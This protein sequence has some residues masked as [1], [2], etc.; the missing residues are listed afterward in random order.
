MQICR[1]PVDGGLGICP[2]VPNPGIWPGVPIPGIWPGVLIPGNWPGV[3]ICPGPG[4]DLCGGVWLLN[5]CGI[6]LGICPGPG[7]DL[8]VGVWLMNLCGIEL[9]I[10]FEGKG[11]CPILAKGSEPPTFWKGL[12]L[13]S[14]PTKL[15]ASPSSS[16]INNIDECKYG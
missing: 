2:G 11:L 1:S 15:S 14:C 12:L 7:I 8:C 9:G 6:E 16:V 5:L 10:C 4:L 13:G 3:P